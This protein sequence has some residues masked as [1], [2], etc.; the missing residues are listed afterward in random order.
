[1]LTFLILINAFAAILNLFISFHVEK[2]FWNI[3]FAAING[4]VV[5]FLLSVGLPA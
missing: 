5:I 4:A 2:L 3:L 1:M